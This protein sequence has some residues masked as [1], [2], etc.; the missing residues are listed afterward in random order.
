MF[1]RRV[2]SLLIVLSLAGPV[3]AGFL[4]DGDDFRV[5]TYTTDDQAGSRA[6]ALTRNPDGTFV[7]VWTDDGYFVAGA[8]G[9]GAGVFGQRF[10][11]DGSALGTEFQVNSYTTGDQR[12]AAIDSMDDGRFLVVWQ[13]TGQ[14]GSA[15][16]IFGQ[17]FAAD[18]SADGTEF[19]VNTYTTFD[20]ARPDVAIGENNGRFVVV[21]DSFQ[22]DG[23]GLGVFGQ[24]FD[25]NG[26]P[27]AEEF[28]ANTELIFDQSHPVVAS[29]PNNRFV[30]AWESFN[31]DGSGSGIFAQRF[32]NSGVPLG[33]ELMVN[34]HTTGEQL[35][36]AVVVA[37][38]FS[39]V[40][41]WDGEGQDGSG[42]GVFTQGFTTAGDPLGATDKQANTFT[43][44]DQMRPAIAL[45]GNDQYVVVW[46]SFAQ[47]GNGLGLFG[48]RMS[49]AGVK[50]G[51]EFAA[52]SYTTGAQFGGTSVDSDE[53]GNFVVAWTSDDQ[54][55][56][57]TGTFARLFC[58]DVDDDTVCNDDDICPNGD[59]LVETEVPPD[60]VPDDCDLCD[61]FDDADDA[62]A[63]GVPD[64]CDVCAGFND[65]TDPD[66][67]GIP[68]NSS[69]A[70]CDVCPSDA[71]N[72]GD[73][74]G[75]CAGN[76]F[77]A[78]KVGAN[79]NC[80]AVANPGQENA[81]GDA[82]G[83]VCDP[84]PTDNP[85]DIDNDGICTSV[86]VCPGDRFNDVDGDGVCAGSG[87]QAPK[88]GD[89]DNCP[90]VANTGQE[91][92]D[93]DGAGDACDQC[94]GNDFADQDTDGLCDGLDEC[95]DDP[96]D[97]ADGDGVCAGALFQTPKTGGN[98][99]CPVAADPGQEDGD[100]DGEGDA[101]DVCTNPGGAQDIVV[102]PRLRMRNVEPSP[103]P[104]DD[105]IIVRGLVKLP[106]GSTFADVDPLTEPVRI[107]VR[108]GAGATLFDE[109]IPPLTFGGAVRGWRLLKERK[110]RYL[111][112]SGER[113]NGFDRVIIARKGTP[114][115]V[116]FVVHG[117]DG[118]Y[119]LPGT[120]PPATPPTQELV[121]PLELSISIAD[122]A[123]SECGE[124]PFAAG[125]CVANGKGSRV[126]C[127]Q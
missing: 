42:T 4:G 5:N 57:R 107:R 41:A 114:R 109:T 90:S 78:P 116:R 25:A 65:N 40:I 32:Q 69:P 37:D 35:E 127:R 20:Q 68:G 124:M 45:D 34:V 50:F 102:K 118:S 75:I 49:G 11:A 79:D 108:D 105:V 33:T 121:L 47:D 54:D 70:S 83:D 39:F 19:Q 44:S 99:V 86:D 100:G 80:P 77:H 22:Q 62:D 46:E 36:P 63:D 13:S 106:D 119:T 101:C 1:D 6:R 123:A 2:F 122:P 112:R 88:V 48:Q 7:A 72:D 59:D 95:P 91:D 111:D 126:V 81:D 93:S 125:D 23:S 14:D 110:W 52:N 87:F 115:D 29:D 76:F 92:T 26:D 73:G 66:G 60:G 53:Q 82:R 74:D 104:N 85:D 9:S 58:N 97:D 55:G 10:N 113:Q 84:C 18:G 117:R 21:W 120:P 89:Q 67:D 30:V 24:R 61:G 27:E 103:A 71:A 15:G 94:P 31:Q 56:S 43:A 38:N 17:R 51:T 96:D 8:D 98:D 12:D 16:G 64:G 28:R 3:E